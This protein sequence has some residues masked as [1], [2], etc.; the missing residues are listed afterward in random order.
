M[1]WSYTILYAG[2]LIQCTTACSLQL[3]PAVKALCLKPL[4]L[5]IFGVHFL[6]NFLFFGDFLCVQKAWR[7][8]SVT[9]PSAESFCCELLFVF[10]SCLLLFIYYF[11]FEI[12]KKDLISVYAALFLDLKRE[13]ARKRQ[14]C[15]REEKARSISH[16]WSFCF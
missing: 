11:F 12:T 7:P 1:C 16:N 5:S 15:S 2:K 14:D 4:K 10:I 3:Y 8:D 13:F 9:V 6:R